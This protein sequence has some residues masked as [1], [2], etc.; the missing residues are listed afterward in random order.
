MPAPNKR[1]HLVSSLDTPALIGAGLVSYSIYLWHY[2]V[3]LW[4]RNHDL[5][6]GGGLGAYAINLAIVAAV[7]GVLSWLTYN[8]VERQALRF[9]ARHAR[10]GK[11]AGKGRASQIGAGVLG[12]RA[13][14]RALVL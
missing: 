10:R 3:I 13:D 14:P 9:K 6:V 12:G 4:L 5:T 2:P 8:L 7:V 1:S 11:E